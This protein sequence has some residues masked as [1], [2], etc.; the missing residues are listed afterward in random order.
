MIKREQISDPDALLRSER[1]EYRAWAEGTVY[2]YVIEEKVTWSPLD[3]AHDRYP[4]MD[5]WETVDSCW[6]FY[7]YAY[8]AEEAREAFTSYASVTRVGL[9]A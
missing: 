8:A 5:T 3:P 6:G 9:N 4:P 7:G 2:G 1:D